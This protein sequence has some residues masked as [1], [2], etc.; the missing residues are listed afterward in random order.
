MTTGNLLYD[1]RLPPSPSYQGRPGTYFSKSWNGGDWP[2]LAKPLRLPLADPF[3]LTKKG[4]KVLNQAI[5]KNN[6]A[7]IDDYKRQ[8]AARRQRIVMR[9]RSRKYENH[10]YS[11]SIVDTMDGLHDIVA[12]PPS[13]PYAA[14]GTMAALF[15]GAVNDIPSISTNEKLVVID[16]L[17]GKILG[18]SFNLG[19]F[20]GEGHMALE[21]I[22]FAARRLTLALHAA[23]KGRWGEA[24]RHLRPAG[25]ASKDVSHFYTKSRTVAMNWLELQYGWLPLVNDLQEGA[26]MLAHWTQDPFTHKVRANLKV[27]GKVVSANPV[28][29]LVTGKSLRRTTIT[30]Y[31]TETNV[32]RLLGLQ[33]MATV[34]WEL[35][36]WSFVAD[37]AIPI[38]NYLNAR[39]V[40]S[41]LKGEFVTS[42][43]EE[44]EC[45]SCVISPTSQ[46]VDNTALRPGYR[47]SG[48][49]LTRTVDNTL[50]VPRPSF[51]GF[52][53]VL[54]W[55][56]AANAVA[57]LTVQA[58]KG[59]L[60]GYAR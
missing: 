12:K 2:V 19:I 29:T 60:P 56:R 13:F 4:K 37:W 38:G 25:S 8:M 33:D 58:G 27:K 15:G 24:A 1:R 32:P 55:K 5:V 53:K 14:T 10:A 49:K 44:F 7:I 17:K 36:P 30:A 28:D 43:K 59:S 50:P 3:T 47:Q 26:Q 42:V 31:L 51:V 22:F 11:M 54:S 40:S 48:T 39:M 18:S 41:S 21:M 6:R 9:L 20:L 23:R 16:R 34:A 35:T 57:L 52:D 45:T 46:W